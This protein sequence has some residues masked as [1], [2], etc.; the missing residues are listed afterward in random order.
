MIDK[1]ILDVQARVNPFAFQHKIAALVAVT[2]IGRESNKT[3]ET[4][5]KIP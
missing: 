1:G 3:M 4:I 2:V 5:A